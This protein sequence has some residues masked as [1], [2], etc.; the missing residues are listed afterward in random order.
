MFSWWIY[1]FTVLRS[2][3]SDSGESKAKREEPAFLLRRPSSVT[4]AP[5]INLLSSQDQ[6]PVNRA[7]PP[8]PP[9]SHDWPEEPLMTRTI[10]Q[11]GD[12]PFP[13]ERDDSLTSNQTIPFINSSFKVEVNGSFHWRDPYAFQPPE[14][15]ALEEFQPQFPTQCWSAPPTSAFNLYEDTHTQMQSYISRDQFWRES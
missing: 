7:L 10:P 14:L 1:F 13:W 12:L 5:F 11:H 9:L 8:P 6:P 2:N 3:R 15:P 4:Q